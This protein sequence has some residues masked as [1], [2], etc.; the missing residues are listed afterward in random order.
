MI[1]T[2]RIKNC[3]SNLNK[4]IVKTIYWAQSFSSMVFTS[5]VVDEVSYDTFTGSF[6]VRTSFEIT[7][8]SHALTSQTIM[9]VRI[10]CVC[11]DTVS[12]KQYV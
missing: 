1:I 2:P 3:I 7:L 4:K 10:I 12:L 6:L 9:F 11:T 8:D 5:I